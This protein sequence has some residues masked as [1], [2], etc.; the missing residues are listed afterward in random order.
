MRHWEE[1][2]F[3][4]KLTKETYL[5]DEHEVEQTEDEPT[6]PNWKEVVSENFSPEL[7]KVVEA[8]MANVCALM[9]SD[10]SNCPALVL[11]GNPSS[12]KSTVLEFWK[13]IA[14][15]VGMILG[16]IFGNSQNS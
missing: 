11:V 13:I 6:L 4:V 9:L 2:W 10:L 14:P 12:A 16:Y 15:L 7:V 8:C 3:R 1:G 5:Q